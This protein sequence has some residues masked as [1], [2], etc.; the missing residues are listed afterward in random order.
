MRILKS[1]SLVLAMGVLSAGTANSADRISYG[2]TATKSIHYTY[3]VS[4]AKAINT[5]SS[6]KLNVTVIA[7]GGA[8]DNLKRIGRKQIQL[9]L[10]SHES[11]YQAYKGLGKFKGKAMTDLRS[12][13][14][15][16]PS[17]MAW[18]VRE[19]SGIKKLEDLN[20]K[21]FTAGQR[22]SGTESLAIQML[23]ALDIKPKLFPATLG[24]AVAAVKDGR[25]NGYVKAGSA[26]SIDGTSLE[27]SALTPIHILPFTE[28][29]I[30]KVKAEFPYISFRTVAE[31]DVQGMPA[32]TTPIQA[33]GEFTTK[34]ALTD[35]QVVAIL[36]GIIDGKKIQEA[37]F[38]GIKSMDIAKD[39]LA[40]MTVPLHAG[41]VKFYK[42]RGFKIPDHLIPSE[43]K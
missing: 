7:T 32:M 4:A 31:G 10:G 33:V 12:L 25:N 20:G 8:V 19:D 17:V 40:V 37:A 28:E 43:L 23:G 6:D 41:A 42:S 15:H 13:W 14:I 16:A 2:T 5:I 34:T 18:V 1:I 38:P 26:N 21:V 27:L 35:D 11:V 36:T 29:H 30:K 24:D 9:A 3:A 22:G 39:S